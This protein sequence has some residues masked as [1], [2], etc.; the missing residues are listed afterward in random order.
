MARVVSTPSAA[1]TQKSCPRGL[2]G[3]LHAGVIRVERGLAES[4]ADPLAGARQ[5]SRDAP[6]A[7]APFQFEN[8]VARELRG[9][10][11]DVSCFSISPE[12]CRASSRA[13]S[14]KFN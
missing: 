1:L 7:S 2:T 3:L 12:P 6:A 8:V 9:E 13:R 4:S 11:A 5:P 14:F 10:K